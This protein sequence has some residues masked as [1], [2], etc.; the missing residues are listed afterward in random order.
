VSLQLLGRPMPSRW[1]YEVID[2]SLLGSAWRWDS[3][4]DR[5]AS[6]R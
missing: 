1:R 6:A 3:D 4:E 5:S 2:D